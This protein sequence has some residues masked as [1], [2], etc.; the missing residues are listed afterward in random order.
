MLLAR[1]SWGPC[2][3]CKEEIKID[4]QF[5]ID[6]GDFKHGRCV[7]NSKRIRKTQ[8]ENSG[9]DRERKACYNTSI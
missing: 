4:D 7:Y 8:E 6:D 5:T 9:N 2:C 3:V 1:K